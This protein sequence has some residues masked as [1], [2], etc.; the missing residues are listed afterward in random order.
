MSSRAQ[1]G[2]PVRFLDEIEAMYAAGIRVFIEAG[3]GKVLSRL[4]DSILGEDRPHL[5]VAVEDRP[6]AGLRGL[7]RALAAWPSGGVSLSTAWLFEGRDARD[8]ES[9]A[10][11]EAGWTWTASSC[12]RRRT[13]RACPGDWFPPDA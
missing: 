1:I 9:R 5:A 10:R 13:A 11:D 3:P 8:A 2:S 7:L 6:D 12:A 4:I